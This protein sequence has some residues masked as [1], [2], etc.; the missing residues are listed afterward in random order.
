MSQKNFCPV[1]LP[2][3][4]SG[5]AEVPLLTLEQQRAGFQANF[6]PRDR[7]TAVWECRQ[8][9]HCATRWSWSC[10]WTSSWGTYWVREVLL[11]L[12]ISIH[13]HCFVR[14][15]LPP[16]KWSSRSQ[17]FMRPWPPA[18]GLEG[19][20]VWWES[21]SCWVT[22]EGPLWL[23]VKWRIVLCLN[24]GEVFLNTLHAPR[25]VG[26]ELRTGLNS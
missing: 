9:L 8:G 24:S 2:Q 25:S 17:S 20:R 18:E 5:S 19:L 6:I 7:W 11:S 23:L 12:G 3:Q 10:G 1:L 4:M 26:V 22:A 13:F 16:L 15:P 14:E 21:C